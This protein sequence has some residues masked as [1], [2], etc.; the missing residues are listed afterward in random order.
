MK[1]TT[2][3]IFGIHN[4]QQKWWKNVKNVDNSVDKWKNIHNLHKKQYKSYTFSQKSQPYDNY[5]DILC[6]NFFIMNV[7]NF[8]RV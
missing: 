5:F 7:D 2:L 8:V 4:Y 1:S 6:I 3:F